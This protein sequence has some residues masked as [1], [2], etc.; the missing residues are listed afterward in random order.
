MCL[1][2]LQSSTA[3]Y[4]HDRKD[5]GASW[6][7]KP[8]NRN[9]KLKFF[10]EVMS[11]LT[12]IS[13][14]G[15]A[16]KATK[17]TCYYKSSYETKKDI[18]DVDKR[19]KVINNDHAAFYAKVRKD[20]SLMMRIS[21]IIIKTDRIVVFK[22]IPRRNYLITTFPLLPFNLSQMMKA[23]DVDIRDG[24]PYASRYQELRS[25]LYYTRIRGG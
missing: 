15:H 21:S 17:I 9:D 1:S 18:D 22:N 20:L 19:M 6:W 12:M 3:S 4:L 5:I 24:E 16:K 11:L 25:I 7:E 23:L 2:T 10:P 8:K 14:I 13:I